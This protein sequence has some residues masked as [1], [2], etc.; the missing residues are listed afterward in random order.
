[1]RNRAIRWS[2]LLEGNN[3]CRCVAQDEESIV[4]EVLTDVVYSQEVEEL[5]NSPVWWAGSIR[6]DNRHEVR[7][8]NDL[9]IV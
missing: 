7:F 1:M 8:T 5:R 3:W 9:G 6:V 2:G 4:G